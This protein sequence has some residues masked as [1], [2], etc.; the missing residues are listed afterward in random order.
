MV[1][2]LTSYKWHEEYQNIQ[3]EVSGLET[4]QW[5]I[6]LTYKI[7]WLKNNL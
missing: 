2:S 1:A 7:N 5:M 6:R 3:I 4:T